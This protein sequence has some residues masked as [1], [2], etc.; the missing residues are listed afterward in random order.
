MRMQA[1]LFV[2]V[3]LLQSLASLEAAEKKITGTI[4]E[5]NSDKRWITV[6]AESG[7]EHL[8]VTVDVVRKTKISVEGEWARFAN[9]RTGQTAIVTYDDTM[10]VATAVAIRESLARD[11]LKTLADLKALQGNWICISEEEA[12]AG[13]IDKQTVRE[14]DRRVTITDNN[15]T[16]KRTLDNKRGTFAGK[17][18]IDAVTGHLN[19]VGTHANGSRLEWT[20]IYEI[21]NDTWRVRYSDSSAHEVPRPVKFEGHE[22]GQSRMYTFKRDVD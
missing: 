13:V 17:F 12:T 2:S 3:M 15:F 20:G 22:N 19:F 7:Q 6:E 1:H 9:I 11:E 21:M 16:M 18:E 10:E 5:I 4:T 14:R 8:S